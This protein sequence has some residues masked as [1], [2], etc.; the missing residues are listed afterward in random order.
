[1]LY[2]DMLAREYMLFCVCVCVHVSVCACTDLLVC[3]HECNLSI[4]YLRIILATIYSIGY[5]PIGGYWSYK[6]Y[7]K[8]P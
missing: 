7:L 1:M 8:V 5:C 3:I 2:I 6:D 4:H